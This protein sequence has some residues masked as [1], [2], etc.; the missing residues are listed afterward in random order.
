M[1]ETFENPRATLD[2]QLHRTL[3][4]F[5][6]PGKALADLGEKPGYFV[7]LVI[8]TVGAVLVAFLSNRFAI[9]LLES[10]VQASLDP[11][12]AANALELVRRL[13]I[14]GYSLTPLFLMLQ[15]F[16][17]AGL[18]FLTAAFLNGSMSF[19]A[20][21]CLIASAEVFSL[22]KSGFTLLI[23]FARGTDRLTSLADLQ[24]P[25]G[26]N[27]LLPDAGE[28]L[29][30][31]LGAVNPFEIWYLVVLVIGVRALNRFS[32][33][34]ASAAVLLAWALITSLR[35]ALAMFSRT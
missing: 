8:A 17:V 4:L 28:P 27:F 18:L 21:F 22:I 13:Q 25:I 26:A 33:A 3:Q 32:R 9:T 31:I 20:S 24:P 23:I 29:Y 11:E 15:W 6:S 16:A 10:N 34:Q 35:A 1:R 30:T 7:P 12:K 5:W 2:R 19:R 14:I